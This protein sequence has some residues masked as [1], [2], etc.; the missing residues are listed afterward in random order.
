MLKLTTRMTLVIYIYN[1]LPYNKIYLRIKKVTYFTSVLLIVAL[2]HDIDHTFGVGVTVVG[3]VRWAIV[4]HGLINGVGGLVR[5]DAC[6]EARDD[7]L[8]FVLVAQGEDVVIDWHVNAEELQVGL[9][10]AVKTADLGSQMDNM[11]W[12]M[13]LKDLENAC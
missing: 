3:G 11:S 8:N 13:L 6:R 5:K 7:L 12:P 4:D 1:L 9:H 10:V 2:V